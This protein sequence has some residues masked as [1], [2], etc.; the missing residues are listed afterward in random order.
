[1]KNL[2]SNVTLLLRAKSREVV[3]AAMSFVKV[4]IGVLPTEELL[5]HLESLVSLLCLYG[6]IEFCQSF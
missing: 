1:M 2:L 6:Y 5:P 4:I 3:K